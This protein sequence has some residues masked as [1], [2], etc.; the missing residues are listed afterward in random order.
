MRYPQAAD[1]P[2]IARLPVSDRQVLASLFDIHTIAPGTH[3]IR[4]GDRDRVL[5]LVLDGVAD[6]LRG[7]VDVGRVV[8][9]QHFGELALVGERPRAASV[10]AAQSLCLAQ[11]SAEQFDQLTVDHPDVA[12]R[13]I[14]SLLRGVGDR[15]EA[16]TDGVGALLSTNLLRRRT[17]LDVRVDG[18]PRTVV[19]GTLARDLLPAEVDG[20]LVVAAALDRQAV[21]L[22]TPITSECELAPV[23]TGSWEGRRIYRGSLALLLLEAARQCAPGIQIRVDYSLG[24]AQRIYVRGNGGDFA[25]LARKLDARMRDIAEAAKPIR[26]ESWAVDEALDKFAEL[27][28]RGTVELLR[29]WRQRTVLLVALGDTYAL[30]KSPL[31][32]TTGMLRGFEIAADADGL[33]LVY[34]PNCSAPGRD[35]GGLVV[36]DARAAARQT[37][38]LTRHHDRWLEILGV[39]TVGEFNSMCL[40]GDVAALINVAE[41]FHEKMVG[42]IADEIRGNIDRI[43]IVSISGPSASGKTTFIKRLMVQLQVNGVQPVSV[44]LDDYYLDRAATPRDENG[45]YDYEAVEALR[46]DLLHDHV[47]RLLN[48]EPVQTAHFDFKKGKSHPN[49]GP[50]LSMESSAVLLLEGIHGLNP[51]MLPPAL[52]D[53]AFRIFVCPLAQLPIDAA[54]RI[55]ASDIRLLRR[56]VRDRHHRATPTADTIR[57]WP[58]VRSGE[59]R[60]IYPFQDNADAIFD[61]SLIY[62]LSV[63]KVY[64]E[65]YLMEV[66][67]TSPEYLT[68]WRLL[69]LTD[70][71]VTIYPDHVP[72]TSILREF[73][74]GS[75]F[76][77]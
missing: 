18:E 19:V 51:R 35:G 40:R 26:L 54:S 65:R 47:E 43:K 6:V 7:R 42:R 24:F 23:T 11:M 39:S 77:Y 64:A 21:S 63:L 66:P 61:S 2:A 73:L 46:L 31:L 1:H 16:M 10:I 8:A 3:I 44:S 49:G 75:G 20:N 58:S 32:P 60:H 53:R 59:R 36:S 34:G 62:E 48:G 72:P 41:G 4:E 70:S 69:A 67:R 71:F 14:R 30:Y 74:G 25:T 55:H 29:T 76:E 15:L 12:V 56:I 27:G 17:S 5:Y 13:F 52:H 22:L 38:E 37:R 45:D 50:R 68:A 33:L 9:G 28:E 57:R